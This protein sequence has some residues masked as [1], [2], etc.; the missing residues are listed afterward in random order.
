MSTSGYSQQSGGLESP[1]QKTV[2]KIKKEVYSDFLFTYML[3]KNRIREETKAH[4]NKAELQKAVQA[5]GQLVS[6]N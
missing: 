6:V 5:L 4:V 2:N 3:I 1:F